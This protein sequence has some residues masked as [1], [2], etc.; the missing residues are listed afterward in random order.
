MK[1]GN[2]LELNC[3]CLTSMRWDVF[4]L[5]STF[6]LQGNSSK[7]SRI[8][9]TNSNVAAKERSTTQKRHGRRGATLLLILIQ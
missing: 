9:P 3:E 7:V 6:F 4:L 1:N 2:M 8:F 5:H